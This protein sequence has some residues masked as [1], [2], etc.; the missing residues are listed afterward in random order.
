MTTFRI[1][2]DIDGIA[3]PSALVAAVTPEAARQ[4]LRERHQG[5]PIVIHKVKLDR[6]PPGRNSRVRGKLDQLSRKASQEAP[7]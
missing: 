4:V 6:D 3:H 1:H 5:D 2:F 7:L